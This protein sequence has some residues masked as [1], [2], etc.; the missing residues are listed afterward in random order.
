MRVFDTGFDKNLRND[1]LGSEAYYG[2]A[3][4][5][6]RAGKFTENAIRGT[7]GFV[8]TKSSPLLRPVPLCLSGVA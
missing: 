5:V 4:Y 3:R 7:F 2:R 1:V 8:A 6:G